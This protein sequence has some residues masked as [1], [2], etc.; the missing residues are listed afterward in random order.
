MI[1]KISILALFTALLSV[2]SCNDNLETSLLTGEEV[3]VTFTADILGEAQTRAFSDG[4]EANMLEYAI[5]HGEKMV[6]SS[7]EKIAANG[8]GGWVI[9]VSLV[10]GLTYDIVFWAQEYNAPFTFDK[11]TGVVTQNY[12]N[13]LANND[14]LDAFY[15]KE[16]IE[17]T[18]P[19]TAPVTLYRPFA[20]VNVA[21][22][23]A[24]YD[25][26]KS[27][28]VSGIKNSKMVV[29]GA[30]YK[31]D[32]L[33]EEAVGEDV[34]ITF[35]ENDI[36]DLA[37]TVTISGKEYKYLSRNYIFTNG[38]NVSVS[39]TV[40]YNGD[41][42][43]EY[44]DIQNVPVDKNFRTNIYGD[45]F[46][47]PVS[48]T[49]SK[50]PGFVDKKGDANEDQNFNIQTASSD[51]A[52]ASILETAAKNGESNVSTSLTSDVKTVEAPQELMALGSSNAPAIINATYDEAA[53]NDVTVKEEGAT[54]SSTSAD[55]STA[56]F[57]TTGSG[58]TENHSNMTP[59]STS[60]VESNGT[61]WN[62]T[63]SNV[64]TAGETFYVGQNVNITTLNLYGGNLVIS[65]TVTN[66]KDSRN[67][68][69]APVYYV[70]NGGEITNEVPEGFVEVS[71]LEELA[72]I[73]ALA[74]AN[75]YAL[76]E[77]LVIS[78][79][80]F[81]ER[82]FTLDLNGHNI[83]GDIEYIS[84]QQMALIE[85]L[86]DGDLTIKGKGTVEV[87]T[88]GDEGDYA[89][90]V[91]G[92]GNLTIEDGEFIG[93][94]TAI[95]VYL[96]TAN[97]KGGTFSQKNTE[98]G[99]A[100][101]GDRYVINCYD[102]NYKEGRANVVVTGGKFKGFNPGV[103]A[104]LVDP[105]SY[106]GKGCISS[107]VNGWYEVFEVKAG[108]VPTVTDY[109]ALKTVMDVF[110]SIEGH[111]TINIGA[112]I[113]LTDAEADARPEYQLQSGNNSV[114]IKGNNHYIEN[115]HNAL[116]TTTGSGSAYINDLTIQNSTIREIHTGTGNGAFV[117]N[118]DT[119]TEI[120]LVNCHLKNSTVGNEN[121]IGRNGGL[122]GYSAGYGNQNDGAVYS[123]ITVRNSSVEGST[124]YG[125]AVGGINGHAGGGAWT[126]TTITDCIVSK[127]TLISNDN[128][129]WRVGTAVGTAGVGLLYITN[130]KNTI[131]GTVDSNTYKQEKVSSTRSNYAY[132]DNDTWNYVF[133]RMAPY[134]K[135]IKTGQVFI[136]N[137]E[138]LN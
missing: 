101:S 102:A 111:H 11:E 28:G 58:T 54:L 93:A 81:V 12:N 100:N 131:D 29:A 117:S 43:L 128:G 61:S 86:A 50:E 57:T 45:L 39:F 121:S 132:G 41:K 13:L 7:K 5:F 108:V 94:C 106:L 24:D 62:I 113:T 6:L 123:I 30:K 56:V 99:Q 88:V 107:E 79:P 49:V 1:K 31:F 134:A 23:V 64:L 135:D 124:V 120:I 77:D 66:I 65:G 46:Q 38:A 133:G 114:T 34:T 122:I 74:E 15:A 35:N 104:E 82:T 68:K 97:I 96:G 138:V 130:L 10:K 71:S 19:M 127:C 44:T 8:E 3:N 80:I 91:R 119:A 18:G 118:M 21:T 87:S 73:K 60:K 59:N 17:V 22:S 76:K 103:A 52:L 89:V 90:N 69:T 95:N 84:G 85:V 63:T 4:V 67:D 110:T 14:D 20:Q 72:L 16:T 36:D 33:N 115:L 53:P 136:D 125:S 83:S 37:E 47:N 42:V 40:N 116:I 126:K 98:L 92:G 55:K 112:D 32:L 51:A 105:K 2:V 26:A 27:I 48:L 25:Y 137:V 9:S 109:A 78:K 129:D 75:S 70:L